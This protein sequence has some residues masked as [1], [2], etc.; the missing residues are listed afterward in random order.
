MADVE[1]FDV[2]V[3]G[4]GPAGLSAAYHLAK[5]G[6]NVLVLER[7]NEIGCK[8]VFGGRIYAKPF[9]K[10]FEGFRT[11]APIERWVYEERLSFTWKD[12]SADLSFF[13][14]KERRKESFT[15][16]LS[17][18]MKWMAGLVESNGGIVAPGMLV[19][20]LVVNDNCVSGVFVDNEKI[21]ADYVIIAEG[22]NGNLLEKHGLWSRPKPKHMAV[23]AKEVI[24]L[25]EKVISE[26]LGGDWG[27][28]WLFVGEVTQGVPGGAFLY[29]MKDYVTIGV[30]VRL[31]NVLNLS[32][33][34]K[35]IV[36]YFRLRERVKSFLEGGTLIEYQAKTVRETGYYDYLEKPYGN[37]Y[38]VIGEA[39]GLIL[40]T[41][42]TIHGVDFAVESG[43]LAAE[44]IEEAHKIGKNDESTL[45]LYKK[46][47][48]E[49]EIFDAMKKYRKVER[50]LGNEDVYSIYPMLVCKF[51]RGLFDTKEIKDPKAVFRESLKG[52]SLIKLIMTM[53]KVML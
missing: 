49:S 6:F 7:G 33:D 23:G 8:N 14:D 30:V 43:R 41:G 45:S 16:F 18:F 31:S 34:V 36:E 29:T 21:E 48:F 39:A 12:L 11:E 5:K 38:L 25:N 19:E 2:I 20:S 46:K 24:K 50:L 44:T 17:K 47:L 37:G 40:N 3:V 27:L 22:S 42:F 13:H 4:G 28:A 32:I 52:Y 9:D 15:T 35:D 10:Y 1:K 53:M 51:M 26:R